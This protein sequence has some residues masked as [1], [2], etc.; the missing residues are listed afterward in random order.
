M[1]DLGA[2]VSANGRGLS[3]GSG[4]AP[5]TGGG[6]CTEF[7][8]VTAAVAAEPTLGAWPS[9]QDRNGIGKVDAEIV[10][11]SSS[12]CLLCGVILGADP[13]RSASICFSSLLEVSGTAEHTLTMPFRRKLAGCLLSFTTK[14]TGGEAAADWPSRVPGCHA[15]STQLFTAASHL[16]LTAAGTGA[17]GFREFSCLMSGVSGQTGA[18]DGPLQER[19]EFFVFKPGMCSRSFLE[20]T[21]A[22]RWSSELADDLTGAFSGRLEQAGNPGPPGARPPPP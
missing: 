21:R 2:E 3:R 6:K 22:L 12:C 15:F 13:G 7:Q 19:Q 8:V 17:V 5:G 14:T 10:V 20:E 18:S 1:P 16:T 11:E 9:S 4:H